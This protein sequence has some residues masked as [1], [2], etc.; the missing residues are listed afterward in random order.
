M[1]INIEDHV[2]YYIVK[3]EALFYKPN[4][5]IRSF[6]ECIKEHPMANATDICRE[7]FAD[8]GMARR[9][10]VENIIYFFTKQGL[11]EKKKGDGMV[12]TEA[13]ENSMESGFVWQGVKGAFMLT[14]WNPTGDIPF[15]LNVQPV[16]ENWYDNARNGNEVIPKEY[17]KHLEYLQPCS[18]KVQFLSVGQS[19]CPTYCDVKYTAS[20]EFVKKDC[21][22]KVSACPNVNSLAPYEVTFRIDND[23]LAYFVNQSVEERF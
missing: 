15:I 13:G 10:A 14:L 18:S 22:V 16:P 12:L 17:G 11:I 8:N 20:A 23:L 2:S 9:A 6:L 1:R 4:M 7:F 5:W 3:G 19:Y 21:F